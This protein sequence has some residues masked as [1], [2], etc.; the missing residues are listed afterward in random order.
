VLVPDAGS[1]GHSAGPPV[2]GVAGVHAAVLVAEDEVG[3]LPGG[4]GGQPFGSLAFPV[5]LKGGDGALGEF[6]RALGLG[7]LD[8]TGAPG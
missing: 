3:V 1:P 6:E 2:E 5:G 7:R 8:L 4:A